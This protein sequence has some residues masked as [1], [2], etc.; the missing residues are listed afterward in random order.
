MRLS[1]SLKTLAWCWGIVLTTCAAGAVTLQVLDV[2]PG[3]EPL[4]ESRPMQPAEAPVQ[5][6]SPTQFASVTAPVAEPA[7]PPT[8]VSAPAAAESPVF[9]RSVAPPPKPHP[10]RVAERLPVPPVPPR[11]HEVHRAHEVREAHVLRRPIVRYAAAPEWRPPMEP[12]PYWR[13]VPY[14]GQYYAYRESWP[15]PAPYYGW[16]PAE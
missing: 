2:V 4:P 1:L 15:R 13:G 8:P 12:Q 6:P 11:S 5:P 16:G 14:P 3:P 9:I 7:P 10:H